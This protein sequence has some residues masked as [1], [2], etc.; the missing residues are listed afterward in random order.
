MIKFQRSEYKKLKTNLSIDIFGRTEDSISDMSSG[1]IVICGYSIA[2]ATP[3]EGW[4]LG[5]LPIFIDAFI[6]DCW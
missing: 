6:I 4:S 2:I 1:L 5:P 3:Q